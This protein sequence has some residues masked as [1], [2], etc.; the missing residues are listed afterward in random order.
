MVHA[1][2]L[3]YT[4]S[5]L[6]YLVMKFDNTL[7]NQRFDEQLLV[8]ISKKNIDSNLDNF[9]YYH[10]DN[11]NKVYSLTLNSDIEYLEFIMYLFKN[12]ED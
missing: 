9:L 2:I 4:N 12:H 11:Y 6:C 8:F 3:E 7:Y 5:M 1:M 10:P